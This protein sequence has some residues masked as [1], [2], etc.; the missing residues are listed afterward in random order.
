MMKRAKL[1]LRHLGTVVAAV[2]IGTVCLSDKGHAE[3]DEAVIVAFGDSLTSGYGLPNDEAFP[4][5]LETALRKRGHKVR[6]VNAGVSG[7]TA[8]AALR[9]LDWALGEET[10]VVIVELGGND[11]LQ[12]LPPDATKVALA[13]ILE[14][15]Q[16][17]NLPV[18]LAG[19][20][21]P[22]NLGKQYVTE[23]GAIYPDLAARYSVPLYPFFLEGVALNAQL[24]QKDG[25]HPNGKGVTVIVDKILPQVE[26]LLDASQVDE[27]G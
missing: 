3:Q 2:W 8:G 27:D 23:F 16:E 12:G 6:V 14:K 11:A 24:M 19:M 10:D 15:I 4:S 22:R 1:R 5:Q 17:K 20:E 7:D 26:A 18:L 9:R 13:K 21:A 25:I